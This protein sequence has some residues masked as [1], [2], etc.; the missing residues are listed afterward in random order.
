MDFYMLQMA[1]QFGADAFMAD[2]SGYVQRAF[3]PGEN[4]QGTAFLDSALGQ[5][6]KKLASK[7]L[8]E[9]LYLALDAA[10]GLGEALRAAETAL[11]IIKKL[12]ATDR[13]GLGKILELIKKYWPL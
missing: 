10:G 12:R 9:G 8:G 7:A 13:D 1:E 5:K 2:D 6:G 4:Y 3:A 11:P